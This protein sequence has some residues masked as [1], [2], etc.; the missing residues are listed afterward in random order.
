[1]PVFYTFYFCLSQINAC[2]GYYCD[3]FKPNS[4]NK[5]VFWTEDWDGWYDDAFLSLVVF[6]P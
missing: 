3:G 6:E 1:M 2:N 4:P 5:P